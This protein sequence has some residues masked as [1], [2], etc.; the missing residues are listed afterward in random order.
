MCSL[1]KT[2][3]YE[4]C[5]HTRRFRNFERDTLSLFLF[6]SFLSLSLWERRSRMHRS[7][8][9]DLVNLVAV[10]VDR[11]IGGRLISHSR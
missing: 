5:T 9:V 7:T 4:R 10:N 6:L 1:G 3:N 2:G 11:L 8:C